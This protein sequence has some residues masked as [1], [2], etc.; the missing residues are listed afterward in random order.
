M[1]K[2]SCQRMV[3]IQNY[4]LDEFAICEITIYGTSLCFFEIIQYVIVKLKLEIVYTS[5]G[6]MI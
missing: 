2:L 6:L 3:Y 4:L 1:M 5:R